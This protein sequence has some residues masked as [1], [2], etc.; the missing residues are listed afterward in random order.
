MHHQTT[1]NPST[2]LFSKKE[3]VALIIPL[4]LEQLLN[5]FVGMADSI[6]IASVG[7][8]AVSGVSLVD[9]VFILILQA[10]TALATG[11]AVVIGHYLGSKD[12]GGARR[13]A[14]QL[15]AF[16]LILSLV[17]MVF[18]Y[19]GQDFI[20]HGVF[21]AIAP[22]VYHHA[23]IYLLICAAAVP[24][25]ALYCGV[26]AIYRA[27]GDSSTPMVIALVMNAINVFGNAFLIYGLHFE[28]A[29]VAIPTLLSR[30]VAAVLGLILPHHLLWHL[31]HRCQCRFH[32][33]G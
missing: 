11:G 25:I 3:L 15:M 21:G 7:E 12:E 23:K 31:C 5:V 20:L 13:A 6:M 1:L 22:D 30:V 9:N 33:R 19:V 28:T 14:D 26:A 29:G 4:M 32:G 24:G 16:L 10:L 17:I 27:Q 8:A 2:L 18:L